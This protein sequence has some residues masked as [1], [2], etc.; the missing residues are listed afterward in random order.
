[1]SAMS[2]LLQEALSDFT[3]LDAW[4]RVRQND[5]A[6]GVD[7]QSI[8]DY[9]NGAIARLLALRQQ[10]QEGS[11]HPDPIL[12]VWMDRPGKKPRPLGIPTVRDRILQ[13]AL[14]IVLTPLLDQHFATCSFAY[15]PAHSLRMALERVIQHR[16][17]GYV[18]VVDADIFSF[19][20]QIPHLNLL[21]K[22]Q[23]ALKDHALNQFIA[24]WLCAPVIHGGQKETSHQGI[25]QGSPLSPLLANL[26]LDQMDKVLIDK[27]YRVVRYADD[28]IVLCKE[29]GDAETAL[30]LSEDLLHLL[31]LR[32]QPEKTRITNF[33]D[34]FHFLGTDFIG[35]TVHSETVDLGPLET[36]TQL[37]K[38]VP[39]MVTMPTP[40]AAAHTNP[41]APN[42]NP[43]S[44]D[45]EEDEVIASV[46]PIPSK[47]ARTAARHTL[48][49]V[50]QGALVGLRAGRIVIRHEGKE[51]Q[52]LPIHRI[53]QM[54]LSGNQL[55]STALL[56]SCRDEGIEVFVSD[57]PGKCDL[58]IDDLSGIGI[59]T[60]GGQFH[61]QE[62]PELL[63][64]TA[65]HIVQGKIANSRTVLRK[66][67]LRRQ[68]EDLS[69]LDLPLRQLQE[70]AL[71]SATLDGLRGIEGGAAR[72]YY[73]G[74]SALIA[75]RWAWPG[76]SRRPPRDPVNAL[77]SYGYGV[78]YRNVLAALHG[79][80]L[81]P[82]I[83]IY[84]QRRPGHP[85]LASDLMEEFRAPIIDRLVLNLLLDPNTQESDFETRP[86]SDYACRIQPSLRK[87][88]IQ[89]FED[90]LNSAIQNPINGE[91]SDYRRIITFQAQQLAQL[92]QGKTPHYQAFTIK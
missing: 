86:D 47:K 76:R 72:L 41:Q 11:Y 52:T 35:D 6:A 4:H 19:F 70:A 16:D 63:L 88:L 66:A 8:P 28:F 84:H 80:H 57:L 24:R 68:N 18:W 82:Y 55:L 92:F 83:G 85:A 69:A 12:R 34:G 65:R 44:A 78:L 7:G 20:D 37:A 53:D 62:K 87:R 26:Y 36:L 56:R 23:E 58:R 13:T 3:L 67:N 75:P 33:T 79:V 2:P 30:H 27:G 32:I 31:Q 51:K 73:Q 64:E 40:Q 29:R 22:L 46:T 49:V 10:V 48:Y 17:E 43:P 89:S 50:E 61:S 42:K 38:A 74:F 45:E 77:L 15:R 1:M 81:N 14:T 60:L 91:S 21:M 90:R 54:H 39:V 5:G 9:A 59:D 71:R 25:P